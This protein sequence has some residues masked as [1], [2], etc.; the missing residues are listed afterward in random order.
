MIVPWLLIDISRCGRLYMLHFHLALLRRV[1]WELHGRY[2]LE[3]MGVTWM[4]QL[5]EFET[6]FPFPDDLKRNWAIYW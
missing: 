3:Y 6:R 1:T 2:M 5:G 4:V